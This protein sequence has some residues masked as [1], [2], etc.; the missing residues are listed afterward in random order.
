[1]V[2]NKQDKN[3][4]K[5]ALE[6]AYYA[7]KKGE[8]PIGAILVFEKNIIGIGWNSSITKNDPT[9][10]AEIIALRD[11][12]KKIK[13]YRL[14]NTT[15]YVTLQPCM[16]CCGAIINSRIERLVF[17]A[18]YTKSDNRNSLKNIFFNLEQDYK[19][20]IKKNILEKECS[21]V[22]MKFFQEK[23]KNKVYSNK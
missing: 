17:G 18:N 3:W 4:M 12:A 23:R 20:N 7:Q 9:A 6:Y 19:L 1:M 15:L 22:L 5:I 2:S 16:M 11:A 14:L 10:H 13:N 21:S 8:V